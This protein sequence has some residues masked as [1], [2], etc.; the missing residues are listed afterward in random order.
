MPHTPLLIPGYGSQGGTAADVRA[1][2]D[3]DGLGALVNSSRGITFAFRTGEHAERFG[4]AGWQDS[5]RAATEAM[6]A[7]LAG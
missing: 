7:D 6:I 4:D 3:A 5:A 2:F 1:A